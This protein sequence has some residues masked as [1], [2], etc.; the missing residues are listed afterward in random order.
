MS[1]PDYYLNSAEQRGCSFQQLVQEELDAARRVFSRKQ[2]SAHEGFAVLLEEVEELKALVW[3][4]QRDRDP[5]EMF[6]ELVQIGAMTQRMAE[7]I[8]LGGKVNCDD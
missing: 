1:H 8:V 6:K 4:K 2:S 5:A 7:E 3:Q